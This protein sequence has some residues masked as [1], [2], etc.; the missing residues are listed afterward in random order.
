MKT[1][2]YKEELEWLE[3]TPWYIGSDGMPNVIL[4]IGVLLTGIGIPIIIILSYK[5]FRKRWLKT[6]I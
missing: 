1:K 4:V 2:N 6:K 5:Y 3:N